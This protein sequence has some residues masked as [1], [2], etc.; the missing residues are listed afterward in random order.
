MHE[1]QIEDS[2]CTVKK[3]CKTVSIRGL[4]APNKSD[5]PAPG[6]MFSVTSI[7][8]HAKRTS[9]QRDWKLVLAKQDPKVEAGSSIIAPS[10]IPQESPYPLCCK[11]NAGD[12]TVMRCY[13]SDYFYGIKPKDT[14]ALVFSSNLPKDLRLLYKVAKA[15]HHELE[16][17]RKLCKAKGKIIEFAS[18]VAAQ[19]DIST[20]QL[21]DLVIS[22]PSAGKLDT[23][24]DWYV[25]YGRYDGNDREEEPEKLCCSARGNSKQVQV[26]CLDSPFFKSFQNK[27]RV[28]IFKAD[29]RKPLKDRMALAF[30]CRPLPIPTIQQWYQGAW[31]DPVDPKQGKQLRDQAAKALAE[32]EKLSMIELSDMLGMP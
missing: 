10:H 7:N 6:G 17:Q 5:K 30:K 12:Q 8:H 20:G 28:R 31:P 11:P 19:P 4:Y 27:D 2:P 1:W 18:S 9:E 23:Q 21:A 29:Y 16:Q 15:G 22:A 13:S 14:I 25:T 32:F 24:E 3:H 26:R